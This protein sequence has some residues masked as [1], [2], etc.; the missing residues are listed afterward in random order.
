MNLQTKL[1]QYSREQSFES[2]QS[3]NFF[4]EAITV[5]KKSLGDLHNSEHFIGDIS[6]LMDN[7]QIATVN[8]TSAKLPKPATLSTQ[9][10]EIEMPKF[11]SETEEF[12]EFA[13]NLE[14]QNAV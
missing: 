7:L 5:M 10:A 3:F 4:N 11:A 1:A 2:E 12:E 6:N 8:F 13:K 14:P 9:T